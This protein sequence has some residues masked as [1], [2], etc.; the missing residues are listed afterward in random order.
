MFCVCVCVCVCV[1]HRPTSPVR[2]AGV[3]R[4]QHGDGLICIMLSFFCSVEA[5]S[6][7]LRYWKNNY[8]RKRSA[9]YSSN[10]LTEQSPEQDY[11]V[12]FSYLV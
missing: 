9:N 1:C 3:D 10:E 11:M 12:I 7:C 6:N 2:A 5:G 4:H 8:R